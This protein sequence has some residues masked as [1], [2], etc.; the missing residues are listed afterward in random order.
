MELTMTGTIAT[1]RN[2]ILKNPAA[3][4][5]T[6]NVKIYLQV[7]SA[8]DECSDEIQEVIRDMIEV[9]NSSESTE[10]EKKAALYTIVEAIFPALAIN[11][12]DACENIRK[13]PQ[14]QIYN[15]ELSRQEEYFADKVRKIMADK[16]ITQ[17]QLADRI[18]IGQ[19]AICNMLNRKCRPQKRTIEK[20]ARALDVEISDLWKDISADYLSSEQ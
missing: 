16:S 10:D 1:N 14:S 5:F 15:D 3:E 9:F 4:L 17:E 20:V 6:E 11:I 2:K 7:K 19:S 18:G 13:N 8:F 12:L